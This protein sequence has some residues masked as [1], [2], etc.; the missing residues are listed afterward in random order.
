MKVHVVSRAV[1]NLLDLLCESF[2]DTSVLG[3]HD[4]EKFLK[5]KCLYEKHFS[6]G[7]FILIADRRRILS[8]YVFHVQNVHVN[9]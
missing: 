5:L 1:N 8:V 2:T 7:V 4:S 9:C 3:R 6:E